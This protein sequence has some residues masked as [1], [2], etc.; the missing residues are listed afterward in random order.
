MIE[1]VEFKINRIVMKTHSAKLDKQMNNKN[2][3]DI[4]SIR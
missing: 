2:N 3:K 4:F 1:N